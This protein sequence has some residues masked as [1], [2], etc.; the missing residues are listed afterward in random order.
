MDDRRVGMLARELRRRLRWRQCDVAERAGVS[1]PTVSRLERGH[2]D[3]LTL[4]TLRRIFGTLDAHVALDLRW[5][6]GLVDRLIDERH[7]ALG[8]SA[9]R[10]LQ[11][12]GWQ[13]IP[14]V[15]FQHYADRG[16]IDLLASKATERAVC[17][18]ELKSEVYSYEETQR[19]LDT[20]ARVA[21]RVTRDRLGW[22][23]ESVG[24]LLVVEGSS[25]NRRR[26]GRIRSLVLAGLPASTSE[27]RRWLAKPA[28]PIR[29]LLF[30]SSM[31]GRTGSA[32]PATPQRVQRRDSA[33]KAGPS[34]SQRA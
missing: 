27:S 8:L 18:V 15:T 31:P 12:L 1:Q 7:V 30:L 23:P 26:L 24:V 20:K 4:S 33:P 28:G 32:R 16:S 19:G 13:V 29:G 21:A 5:R 2:L 11:K 34:R 25:T 10:M 3:R 14:E 6:G 17:I 22:V 9:T